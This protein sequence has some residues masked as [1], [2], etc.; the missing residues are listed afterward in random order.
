MRRNNVGFDREKKMVYGLGTGSPD[1]VGIF[2]VGEVGVALAVEY[3]TPGVKT[4]QEQR[5]FLEQFAK[6]GGIAIIGR[7]PEQVGAVL[8]RVREGGEWKGVV[9]E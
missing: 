9:H 8:E 6:L 2:P 3:K 1:Y 5:K 4:T 7:S